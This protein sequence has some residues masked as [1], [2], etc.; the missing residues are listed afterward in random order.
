[1]LNNV[2]LVNF[3]DLNKQEKVMVLTW[4]NNENVKKWMYT[5]EDILI[6]EHLSFIDKLKKQKNKLYFL[7][8]KEN[9]NLGVIDFI[10]I[11][12]NISAE[13]GIYI[14]PDLKNLGKLFMQII[15]DYAFLTLKVRTIFSE[16]FEDNIKALGLYKK[17]GFKDFEKKIIN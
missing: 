3:T 9:E 4:R 5:T 2:S 17:F 7:V 10:N 15:I 14:N 11:N 1:M 13:M 16:V 8:K 12:N 6:D